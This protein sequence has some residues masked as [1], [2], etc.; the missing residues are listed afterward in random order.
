MTINVL[1]FRDALK[2]ASPYS[3]KNL[4]L[5]NGFSIACVPT[6][7]TYSSLYKQADFSKMPEVKEVFENLNTQDFEEVI[8]ALEYTSLVLPSYKPT[9]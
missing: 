6:I 2:L 8:H 4:L 9:L 3:K 7:F 1:S 5:G